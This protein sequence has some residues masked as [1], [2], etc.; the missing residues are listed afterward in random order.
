M[1]HEIDLN[2]YNIRTDLIL[3]S[4][5]NSENKI[6]TKTENYDG[7]LVTNV[8]VDELN[9]KKLNKEKGKYTTIQFEDITDS[10]NASKIE[11]VFIKILKEYINNKNKILII[12]LGN[13]KSTPDSLGPKTID[14][15]IVTRHLFLLGEEVAEGIKEVSGLSPGVMANTGI[16]T[17]DYIKSLVKEIKPDVIIAVDALAA[18]TI[19]RVNKSIQITDTG[20]HPGSGVG[21][22]RKEI[23]NKT[24]GIPVVAVG[25]PTVVESSVIVYDTINYLFKHISYIKDNQDK[26]KLIINRSNYLKKI[27]NK[28]LTL[29]EKKDILG[30][31]GELSEVDKK[32]LIDEVLTSVNYN[33]IVTP[34]EIDFV[35]EKL[36]TV[37]SNGINKSIHDI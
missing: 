37:I 1:K 7:V 26:N 31:V 12:G 9:S 6:D 2:K 16:E 33:F 13:N 4:I 14:K 32:S 11:K 3:E 18:G 24:L 34:K 23:S 15:I 8:I 36:S 5:E 10:T 27:Q 22:T 35:I 28:N 25:V 21:N 17:S 19:E 20:I 30:V 29:Q